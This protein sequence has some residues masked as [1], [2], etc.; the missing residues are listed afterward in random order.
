M[1]IVFFVVLFVV[2]FFVEVPFLRNDI[3]VLLFVVLF[4]VGT[5]GLIISFS[6]FALLFFVFIRFHRIRIFRE[7]LCGS[8][9][10][11]DFGVGGGVFVRVHDVMIIVF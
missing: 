11:V 5:V 7:L 2:P 8:L 1:L 4:L 9:E 10:S 6:I 3:V